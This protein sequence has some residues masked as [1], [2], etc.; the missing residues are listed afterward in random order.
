MEALYRSAR[1]TGA[2]IVVAAV[3]IWDSGTVSRFGVPSGASFFPR[4][5]HG[6]LCFAGGGGTD[7]TGFLFG[8][9]LLVHP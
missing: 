1:R 3:N 2:D 9:S 7:I 4:K 6:I 5:G 8:L